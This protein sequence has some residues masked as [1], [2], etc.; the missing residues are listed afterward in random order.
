NA[1]RWALFAAL[2]V[3][4]VASVAGYLLAHR[5]KSVA[6]VQAARVVYQCPMHPSYTSD[7]PGECPICGMTLERVEVGGTTAGRAASEQ[8]SD[9]PGLAAV[10]LEPERIQLIGVRTARVES[11]P[12][13][14]RLDLVGFVAPDESRLRRVQIRAA[15]WIQ[16]LYVTETGAHV[17]A[18]QPLLSI[19]SPELY[20]SEQEFLIEMGADSTGAMGH[21]RRAGAAA[22]QRLRLLG[23]PDEEIARLERERTASSRLTLHAPFSGT[24]LER[25]V[26]EGQYVSA[27]TPL[28]TVA[29]LSRV[30]VLADVYEM[31]FTR[32]KAGDPARFTADALPG[33]EF[34]GRI[35][36]VYPTVSSETR[37][38]KV[39]ME[40]A[41]LGGVLRPG[42]YGRVAV[43]AR[44]VPSLVVPEE[45]VVNTGENSYVFIA[46]AGGRFEPRLV[47]VG[48]RDGDRLQI[49][50]GL[51]AG[52][53]VVSSASFLIDSESRLKA[54]IA[55]MGGPGAKPK[56]MPG[57][58]GMEGTP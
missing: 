5:P 1:V 38:I 30:W 49:L 9:V 31:D 36:F 33:R 16:T 21:E 58:P 18:G 4:A 40:L 20:Q 48:D 24:V 32:V 42:M 46:H 27:D 44:G 14:G 57:M 52:D 7:K 41:N 3:L 28:F 39:R 50:H 29:D 56:G 55:G 10:T 45:A 15:G 11:R 22:P 35:A 2:L 53:T 54:A 23:V 12:L 47:T 6:R 37:T 51:A 19:Y 13:G 17:E 25:G 8:P 34:E 43:S 26:A